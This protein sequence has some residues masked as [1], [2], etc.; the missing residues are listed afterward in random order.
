MRR[1]YTG[2]N[3]QHTIVLPWLELLLLGR[4]VWFICLDIIHLSKIIIPPHRSTYVCTYILGA[5]DGMWR[6]VVTAPWYMVSNGW[7]CWQ[8]PNPAYT[9]TPATPTP[10]GPW[11][12]ATHQSGA[13]RKRVKSHLANG[14]RRQQENQPV[15]QWSPLPVHHPLKLGKLASNFHSDT[16]RMWANQRV[17]CVGG[18]TG[19]FYSGSATVFFGDSLTRWPPFSSLPALALLA[20]PLAALCLW[21]CLCLCR[22]SSFSCSR[23]SGIGA[24]SGE[25]VMRWGPSRRDFPRRWPGGSAGC[26]GVTFVAVFSGVVNHKTRRRNS[27]P[28]ILG[29]WRDDISLRGGCFHARRTKL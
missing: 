17:F 21:L 20:F 14:Q 3:T 29:G 16:R 22:F 24:K 15:S 5:Y 11:R 23:R 12:E 25:N 27:G 2:R 10:T 4:K 28:W 18:Q 8:A 6:G 1:C 7:W 26:V 9:V 19:F 13:Q